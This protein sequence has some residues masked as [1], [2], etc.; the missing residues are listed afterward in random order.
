[1][2]PAM[3]EL[4]SDEEDPDGIDEESPCQ[5]W[6][7]RKETF[8][9]S[10]VPGTDAA[11]LAMDMEDGVE[12]IWNE[13]T[14]S[15]RKDFE[16]INDQMITN[17]NSL[18]AIA[19]PNIV[20]FHDHWIAPN[21][22]GESK[23]MVRVVFITEAFNTGGSGTLKDFLRRTKGSQPAQVKNWTRWCNQILSSLHYMHSLNTVHGNL[24]TET[25][26]LQHHGLLKIG[27]F[28]I[29]TIKTSAA[30]GGP[31]KNNRYFPDEPNSPAF[32]IYSF[33]VIA[34][35][36]LIPTLI[37]ESENMN[38]SDFKLALRKFRET[39]DFSEHDG[40]KADF[41]ELCLRSS[42]RPDAKALSRHK[43]VFELSQLQIL[44]AHKVNEYRTI[45]ELEFD[46]KLKKLDED[47]EDKLVCWCVKSGER[48]E[49]IQ[50]NLP[51]RPADLDK[52]ILDVQNGLYPV[53]GMEVTTN[54]SNPKPIDPKPNGGEMD[55]SNEFNHGSEERRAAHIECFI[56]H[57]QTLRGFSITIDVD[58]A[59]QDEESAQSSRT[60][61]CKRRLETKLN[62]DDTPESIANELSRYAFI[63]SE[64]VDVMTRVIQDQYSLV[65]PFSEAVTA[66]NAVAT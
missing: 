48:K 53:N 11:Y 56:T 27:C 35:E 54:G 58:L 29:D 33:G 62:S 34:L 66:S 46:D 43:S 30:A 8:S 57:D 10:V 9:H 36:M 20:K 61:E 19:H 1:M 59:K 52:L 17:L 14:F 31:I 60:P 28:S 4:Y 26:F 42:G 45:R 49:F 13:V 47:E 25:I 39:A 15:D 3:N 5:R 2:P 40:D 37:N 32:D 7:K 12:V 18:M 22:V 38:V 24:T 21:R 64:D 65:K 41:I 6:H 16:L 44:A 63:S 55:K 23:D 50:R 51:M